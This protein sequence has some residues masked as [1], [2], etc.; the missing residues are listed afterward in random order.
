ME[1]G[2]EKDLESAKYADAVPTFHGLSK[3]GDVEGPLVFANYGTKEDFDE[4]V[5]AGVNFTGKI[6]MTRY[7]ANYRGLKVFHWIVG[8]TSLSS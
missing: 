2:D 4:L 8:N 6:V 7:G 3:E 1:H 5:A